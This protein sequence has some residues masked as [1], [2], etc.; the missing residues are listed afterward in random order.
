MPLCYSFAFITLSTIKT[1]LTWLSLSIISTYTHICVYLSLSL[2]IIYLSIM[3]IYYLSTYKNMK[4][5]KWPNPPP[6]PKKTL[7][8]QPTSAFWWSSHSPSPWPWASW[9]C[10]SSSAAACWVSRLPR[11][12]PGWRCPSPRVPGLPLRSWVVLLPPL[13]PPTDEIRQWLRRKS[14]VSWNN[15]Q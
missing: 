9:W 1:V 14:H 11:A 10:W 5:Y 12:A 4:W 3:H 6:T 7:Q 13:G 2:Y 8:Q 15:N